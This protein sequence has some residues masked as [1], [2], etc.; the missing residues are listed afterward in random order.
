MN[1]LVVMIFGSIRVSYLEAYLINIRFP[2][3]EDFQNARWKGGE[4]IKPR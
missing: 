4:N 3:T 2:L 1:F